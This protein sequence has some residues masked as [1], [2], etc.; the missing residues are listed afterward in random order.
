MRAIRG[1]ATRLLWRENEH[2]LLGRSRQIGA[3]PFDTSVFADDGGHVEKE[4][5][6]A[7][8][9]TALIAAFRTRGHLCARLDPL[10]RVQGGPWY[11]AAPEGLERSAERSLKDL[12]RGYQQHDGLNEKAQYVA[13]KIQ[14]EVKTDGC[15]K[16]FVGP[17]MSG[18][19]EQCNQYWNLPEIIERM[20]EC[21]CGTLAVE[22]E[23]LATQEQAD[24]LVAR[25]ENRRQPKPVIKKET[26]QMLLNADMF[27]RFLGEKFPGSKRFGVEGCES[28]LSGMR[29]IIQRCGEHGVSKVEIGIAHRGRLNILCNLLEK[30]LGAVCREMD[31]QQSQLHVGDVK[32]HLGRSGTLHYMSHEDG[33]PRSVKLSV[34][35]NPSHLEAVNPVIVGMVR[36]QQQGLNDVA[37]KK[38]MGLLVHGDAAFSGLGV[39]AETLQLSDVPGFTTGGVIHVVINNQIGFTTL[40]MHARSGPHATDVVKMISAP[41]LHANAD[42]PEA[43]WEA[44]TIAADWRAKFKKDI[45]IDIVGY[46]RF[47]HNE[48]DNPV[49]NMPITYGL[50]NKHPR[51]VDIYADQLKREGVIS[52]EEF[53][54]WKKTVRA[55]FEKEWEEAERGTYAESVKDFLKT[56]WQGE[57]LQELWAYEAPRIFHQEPTG[58]PIR[59]LQ[60]VGSQICELGKD[61]KVHPDILKILKKRQ[62][63]IL[64]PDSRVDWGMAEALAYG[65]LVLHRGIVPLHAEGQEYLDAAMGLNKGHYHVRLTGQDVERGTFNHRQAVYYDQATGGRCI[66]HNE[67]IPGQ[68]DIVEIWNSPLSESAVMGFEYGYS[69][70]ARDRALVLWEAQFGDFANNAQVVIDQFLA[71]GEEKW[72]QQSGLVLL[73]PHGYDGQG[74]DHSSARLERFLAVCNDDPDHLSGHNPATRKH[75]SATFEAISKEYGGK[76][77]RQQAVDVFRAFR[78]EGVNGDSAEALDTLWTEMGLPE[79]APLTK[80]AWE[81]FM[82]QYIRR[83]AERDTNLFVVNATTP[84][85]LFHVLRR[86]VNL[87]YK[88]PLILMSPK[89]LLHHGPCTSSLE[90][91][92]TG[93][94]F[95]RVIDDGKVSDNTRHKAYLPGSSEEAFLLPADQIRRVIMCSGQIYYHL[96]AARR[97]RR[98]RDV[99]FVRLE[100]ICPFPHDRITAIVSQYKDAELVWCQEEPKN[101]GA[102]QFVK[103]RMDTAMR[104]LCDSVGRKPRPV[105]YIGRASSAATATASYRIHQKETREIIDWALST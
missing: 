71:S 41:V 9:V 62:K 69:L 92:S 80:S 60:F 27:E 38:V 46:R 43:V 19:D 26:L 15:R 103:P 94:F 95:N 47:G 68:Q 18:S 14:L 29:T 105:H 51:V 30:P 49:P 45:V 56:N 8:K 76:I 55:E 16:F 40:P 91:F 7:A 21:Y 85:Q 37:R 100:Q 52:E 63:M 72:G 25:V 48:L 24:W 81:S 84:A 59:T 36:A 65:T 77:T 67:I 39:V 70:G 2:F 96:N 50:I 86:Q 5:R 88:K 75:I 32:Y 23:H 73:L 1:A 79:K 20:A 28:V 31:G 97:A 44:C 13:K 3:F 34:A 33:I 10:N 6:D 101:M 58:L 99:V 89:F 4:V 35:P 54:L 42:D 102:W 57:A 83:N 61:F 82:V 22:T 66:K 98:I 93:T 53:E 64:G 104:E 11:G 78:V 17:V 90:D 12:L 74:P 87:P